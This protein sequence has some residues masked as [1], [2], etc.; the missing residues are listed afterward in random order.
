MIAVI[1][2]NNNEF[3]V[4]VE[5]ELCGSHRRAYDTFAVLLDG[6]THGDGKILGH[7]NSVFEEG[8]TVEHFYCTECLDT[9]IGQLSCH[10]YFS[11]IFKI[12]GKEYTLATEC[13]GAEYF[14]IERIGRYGKIYP[15]TMDFYKI[16]SLVTKVKLV[17][18]EWIE[19]VTHR[20]P[21]GDLK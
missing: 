9:V 2:K 13:N 18:F 4:D 17:T 3:V 21:I 7:V 6:W 16:K 11:L 1:Q 20:L 8:E 19:T 10:K 12:N 5:C 15:L 14:E